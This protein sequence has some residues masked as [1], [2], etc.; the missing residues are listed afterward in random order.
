[1]IYLVSDVPDE[2]RVCAHPGESGGLI[3][4][5][6]TTQEAETKQIKFTCGKAFRLAEEDA[7]RTVLIRF[8]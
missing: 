3:P 4:L 1:M 5:A 2:Y 7:E 8:R 6:P